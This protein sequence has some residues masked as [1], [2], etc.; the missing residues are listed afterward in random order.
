MT[1]SYPRLSVIALLFLTVRLVAQPGN[2]IWGTR[3]GGGLNSG[4]I[5]NYAIGSN[6][7]TNEFDYYRTYIGYLPSGGAL[8]AGPDSMIYGT[9]GAGTFREKGNIFKYNPYDGVYT[10]I[11]EIKSGDA[12]K[13]PCN[14]LYI[15]SGFVMYGV[16]TEGGGNGSIYKYEINTNVLTVL[17]LL[18]GSDGMRPLSGLMKAA[19]GLFYGSTN[20][21][22]TFGFGVIYSFDPVTNVYSVLHHFNNEGC[23][24]KLI[25]YSPGN[26]YGVGKTGGQFALGHLFKLELNSNTFTRLHSFD[27]IGGTKPHGPLLIAS[28]GF[29]YGTTSEGGLNNS[30]TIYR[31]DTSGNQYSVLHHFNG[32]SKVRNALCEG[33]P[34]IFYGSAEDVP[35]INDGVVFRFDASSGFL[36]MVD[37]INSE[38]NG[39]IVENSFIKHP[40]GRL[41]GYRNSILSG[42]PAF[43]GVV[44]S[45]D[46]I[47][48]T[49][50]NEFVFD[51]YPTG[52]FPIGSYVAASDGNLYGIHA[53][54]EYYFDKYLVKYSSSGDTMEVVHTFQD[55]SLFETTSLQGNLIEKNGVIW[56]CVEHSDSFPDGAVFNYTIQTGIYAEV[57]NFDTIPGFK[58]PRY[59]QMGA[60]GNFYGICYHKTNF[61]IEYIYRL[62]PLT[63]QFDTLLRYGV[64]G[65]IGNGSMGDLSFN[66]ARTKFSGMSAR[67]GITNIGNLFI[68]DIIGDSL[69]FALNLTDPIVSSYFERS[70]HFI[71]DSLFI[72]IN[73]DPTYSLGYGMIWK[74]NLTDT[75]FANIYNY[76]S[77][78]TQHYFSQFTMDNFDLMSDGKIYGI[79]NISQDDVLM[80][81]NPI[82][83]NVTSLK[84]ITSQKGIQPG[85]KLIELPFF[86]GVENQ[87]GISS[88]LKLYPNPCDDFLVL[89]GTLKN[90]MVSIYD[91]NGRVIHEL[92][93]EDIH[94]RINTSSLKQG[95]YLLRYFDGKKYTSIKFIKN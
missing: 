61:S 9:T 70:H 66:P 68:Y 31:F 19:N 60:D 34:G 47:T 14:D 86:T 67:T 17:H 6:V 50:N 13:F 56:G 10:Q 52:H 57:I 29:L 25:E 84:T 78:L 40:N 79:V 3:L 59:F 89:K 93:S 15:D 8:T 4:S 95:F 12:V 21:G 16:S 42:T 71:N 76:P 90:K 28:D 36:T 55:R 27:I 5:L 48:E 33:V 37:T 74:L 91:I 85:G 63:L 53:G 77:T 41:Y 87:N 20:E 75:S 83:G 32:I 46:P 30:G 58:S 23:T 65:I 81:I 72:G 24:G 62:N 2:L 88:V 51:Q 94:T 54:S 39:S 49:V 80:R 82:T 11:Y 92:L 73:Y 43:D 18:N 22:G 1:I 45:V 64:N 38:R 35:G 26:L 7:V 44:V 69:T